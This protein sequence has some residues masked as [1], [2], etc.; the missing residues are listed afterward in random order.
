M[1]PQIV[2]QA[3]IQMQRKKSKKKSK[4]RKKKKSKN[5]KH[6][7]SVEDD[8]DNQS[9]PMFETTKIDKDEIPEVPRNRF[10]DRF[11]GENPDRDSVASS[12]DKRSESRSRDRRDRRDNDR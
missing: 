6:R 3:Q 7:D 2:I 4:K 12:K 8:V 11:G 10:L 5:R 1:G 9:N